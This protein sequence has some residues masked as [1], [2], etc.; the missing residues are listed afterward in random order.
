MHNIEL[1]PTLW[2]GRG[3]HMEKITQ[4]CAIPSFS[5]ISSRSFLAGPSPTI[6]S[7]KLW[8]CVN[9]TDRSSSS[10]V[11]FFSVPSLPRLSRTVW[12]S[13][14]PS[15]RRRWDRSSSLIR[16]WCCSKAIPEGIT[17]MGLRMP[18]SRNTCS[19][20]WVGATKASAFLKRNFESLAT[21]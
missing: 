1:K 10:S 3:V 5:D 8:L 17:W 14:I 15:S 11:K 19:T 4:W 9:A 12:F 18:Y 16:S 21:M 2:T 13:G 6:K 7:V 20:F